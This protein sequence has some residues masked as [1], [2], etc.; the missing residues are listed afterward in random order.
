MNE[1]ATRRE[2]AARAAG[3]AGAG[4]GGASEAGKSATKLDSYVEQ[5]QPQSPFL[6][7]VI[8]WPLIGIG[9]AVVI[10]ATVLIARKKA[11]ILA[12]WS[13]SGSTV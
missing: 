1:A 3:V 8:A 2:R 11:A 6:P 9:I 10:V 7:P 4:A 5:P 13:G 12:K